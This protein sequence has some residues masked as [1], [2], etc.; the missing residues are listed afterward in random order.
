MQI[1]SE[2]RCIASFMK[3]AE[4]LLVGKNLA[5]IIATELKKPSEQ[6]GFIHPGQEQDVP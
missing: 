3:L 4:H 6:R 2:G 1:M 5:G